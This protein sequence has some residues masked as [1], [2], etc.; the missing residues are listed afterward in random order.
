MRLGLLIFVG[1]LVTMSFSLASETCTSLGFARAVLQQNQTLTYQSTGT[2]TLN[3]SNGYYDGYYDGFKDGYKSGYKDGYGAGYNYTS[4]F[5]DG[6]K[7]GY[8]AGYNDGFN[9]RE[10]NV[11]KANQEI[12]QLNL[13]TESLGGLLIIFIFLSIALYTHRRRPQYPTKS[14]GS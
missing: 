5:K 8:T 6:Y 10:P 4:A 12:S 9:D 3:Y 13:I 14:A 2:R 11:A 7:S 1:I